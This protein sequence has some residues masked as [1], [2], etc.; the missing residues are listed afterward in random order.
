MADHGI[1]V[2]Q[3]TAV[4]GCPS[5]VAEHIL[6]AHDWNVDVAINFYLECGGIGHGG[7][8]AKEFVEEALA[9]P[10][11]P[12]TSGRDAPRSSPIDVSCFNLNIDT[13][14]ILTK[15]INIGFTLSCRFLTRTKRVTSVCLRRTWQLADA[16][17]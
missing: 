1:L 5:H 13:Q 12:L 17:L 16:T 15:Q 4:T 7:E 3:F 10:P 6:E 8:S 14:M 9:V 11:D 2:D